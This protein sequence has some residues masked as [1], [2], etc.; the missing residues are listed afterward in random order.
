MEEVVGRIFVSANGL[1]SWVRFVGLLFMA[2]S[3]NFVVKMSLS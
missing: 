2:E 1:R 3:C